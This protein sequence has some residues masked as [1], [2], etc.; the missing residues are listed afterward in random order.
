MKLSANFHEEIISLETVNEVIEIIENNKKYFKD[1]SSK[2]CTNNGFQSQNIINIFSME[3][4]KKIISFNNF[5]NKTFHIHYIKYR[6]NGSQKRHNHALTEKYSFILYLNN[7][8]GGTVFFEPINK[9]ICPEK[10]KLIVFD[11]SIE[12]EATP[13][14]KEKQILVGAIEKI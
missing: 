5:F 12:H 2:T 6:N 10:G 7:S 9:M 1:V 3:L 14:F 8:D 4:L 13:S 11:S